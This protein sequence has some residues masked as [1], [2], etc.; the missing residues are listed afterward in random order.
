[1]V[2]GGWATHASGVPVSSHA[3]VFTCCTPYEMKER[4]FA[5]SA[6][7]GAEFVRV[8][9]QLSGIYEDDGGGPAA[10]PDWRGLDEVIALSREYDVRVLAVLL[11]PP[12]WISSCPERWPEHV[13]CAADDTGE[14]GRLAGEVAAHAG[15]AIDHWEIVNEPDGG[16]AFN[17]SPEE[18]ARM[19]DAAYDGIKARAAGDS[20]VLGGLMRPHETA[21]LERVLAAPGADAAHSFDI[22]NVHLRG[23]VGAV[24]ARYAEV[25]GRLA[26]EAGF[27][28]PLWVTE[29]GYPADPAF[30]IDPAF[31]AGGP[32]QAGYLTQS[33]VGLGEAGAGQVF[34]TLRDHAVGEYSTEGVEAMVEAP[35]YAVTRRESFAA[36]Q[37]V[38]QSWNQIIAWRAEQ[39][40][41]ESRQAAL[42]RSASLA[43][44]PAKIAR[45]RFAAARRLAHDT[46]RG[47]PTAERLAKA[48]AVTA[49]A[50][51]ELGWRRA[52]LAD[53]RGRAGLHGLAAA[54]LRAK[55][56]G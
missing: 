48:R 41:H 8:D 56:A 2:F 10:E 52:L 19:L 17:G 7:L 1:M 13:R 11:H 23:T 42:T 16:W 49:Q 53:F 24:V 21:W 28:G 6:E 33:L 39:R 5:E 54:D 31:A 29:H 34:V 20:V 18:Y 40:Q 9:V 55:I 43:I 12:S 32:S 22:A 15:D 3:M 37:R 38:A 25:Q 35:G 47:T 44:V 36:V 46:Q 26:R 50:R 30:Q 4:I 45:R 51:A 14:F 27:Q